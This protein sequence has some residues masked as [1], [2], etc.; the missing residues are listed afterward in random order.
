MTWTESAFPK[1]VIEPGAFCFGAPGSVSRMFL[2]RRNLRSKESYPPRCGEPYR[3]A[4]S[5]SAVRAD[6]A[7]EIMPCT[8]AKISVLADAKD[9]QKRECGRPQASKVIGNH[10][11]SAGSF[12]ASVFRSFLISAIIF[13][14]RWPYST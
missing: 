5:R 3:A 12:L 11:A 10:D 7:A 9:F 6:F 13:S 2:I 1:V 14:S 8:P 4:L